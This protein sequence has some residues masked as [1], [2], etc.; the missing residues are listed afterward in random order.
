MTRRAQQTLIGAVRGFADRH[1]DDDAV[2]VALSGGADSLALTAAAIRAGL[3]V[4][5]VVI[6]HRLQTGSAAVAARAAETAREVGASA[7]VRE[8]TVEGAGGLEAAARRARYAA[9]GEARDARPVLLG[10][11]LDDQAETVLLGLARGS[12]ARSIAGMREWSAPWGRPL[13][14]VRRADT[15]EACAG[16]RLPVWDDPHNDDPRFTRVRIRKEVLPLLD[17][18]IGGGAAESLARTASQLQ[19]DADA[20]DP[21]ATELLEQ[22]AYGRVLDVEPLRSAPAALRTRVLRGWLR[23]VGANDPV[24]RVVRSVDALITDWRGQGPVAVG[25]DERAR[26]VVTRRAQELTVKRVPR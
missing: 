24:Y 20:L 16:W 21:P 13:L 4:H 26:L 11:T 17:E 1:L 6:D 15:R 25:G 23:S 7:E 12:G 3:T 14:G 8:V 5:A 22:C 9:L 18:V 10:H 19:D 2:C